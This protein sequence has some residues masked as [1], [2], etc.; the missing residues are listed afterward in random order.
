[1]DRLLNPAQL[2]DLLG[3]KKGTVFS[4][5][6]RGVDLPPFVKIGGSTR[7]REEAVMKWIQDK[8]KARN[9]KNFKE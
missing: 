4:W 9:R 8:E 3:V 6:S 1:M 2:A 7:W 5:L